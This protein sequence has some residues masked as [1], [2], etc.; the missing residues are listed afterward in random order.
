MLDRL[1]EHVDQA[2][3]CHQVADGHR[4]VEYPV[5]AV[6]QHYTEADRSQELDAGEVDGGENGG[7]AVDLAVGLVAPVE[8]LGGAPLAVERLDHP[9]PGDALLEVGGDLGYGLAGAAEG[10]HALVAVDDRP[11]D[12]YG[13][14]GRDR[15]RQ[16]PVEE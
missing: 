9:H 8:L 13:E 12:H 10:F 4:V 2:D 3:K 7:A 16:P 1:E 15:E 11:E 14:D 6:Y 5:T